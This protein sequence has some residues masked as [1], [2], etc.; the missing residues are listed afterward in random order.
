MFVD[1]HEDARD[2]RA[3]MWVC[4]ILAVLVALAALTAALVETPFALL[5]PVGP[6]E[7]ELA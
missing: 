3:M 7:M 1:R 5:E 2:V 4:T 6:A